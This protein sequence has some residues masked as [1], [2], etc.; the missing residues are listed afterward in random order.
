MNGVAAQGGGDVGFA[1]QTDHADGQIAQGCHDLGRGA[2]ADL[3]PVFI[4]GNVP[5]PVDSVLDAPM[6]PP[7]G[8]EPLRTGPGRRQAGNSVSH[9]RRVERLRRTVRSSRQTWARWGQSL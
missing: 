4:E 7:Q 2:G 1:S 3:G 8:E 6:S 9:S 5:D